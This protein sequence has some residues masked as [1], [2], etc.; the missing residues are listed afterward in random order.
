MNLFD[1]NIG[2]II[3]IT[4]LKFLHNLAVSLLSV[5]ITISLLKLFSSADLTVNSSNEVLLKKMVLPLIGL[6]VKILIFYFLFGFLF[7]DVV[8]K[9]SSILTTFLAR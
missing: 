6:T 9:L 2:L 5:R 7:V 4:F 1:K 8:F 3:G